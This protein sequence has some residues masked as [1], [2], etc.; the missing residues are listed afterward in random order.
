MST[1]IH[2]LLERRKIEV[3]LDQAPVAITS[4]CVAAFISALIFWK[5]EAHQ[6]ILA[7]LGIYLLVFGLRY[8]LITRFNRIPI[9]KRDYNG[10]LSMH[11]SFSVAAGL[12][13]SI[14]GIYVLD[15]LTIDDSIIIVLLVGGMV[16]GIVAT[17]SVLLKTYFAFSL[18]ASLP[19]I[20]YLLASDD[21]SRM[22]IMG[23]ML[24][25]FVLFVSFSAI[26]LNRLV[27]KSLAFQFDN[28]QL[29]EELEKE[30]NQVSRLASNL[31]FDLARRK[32]TEEQL[33]VEKE[34]AEQLAQSLL[35]M[36]TLD[37][38][39]GIPNRRHF[40]SI[41]AKEWNRASRTSSPISLIMCDIDN[42]KSYNDNYGH[43][44][45]DNCLIRIALL[46]QEHARREGDLAARYGGE[47]FVIILPATSLG[48]AT[49]IAEQMR[50]AIEELSI[51][52]RFSTSEN[53]VTASFGVATIVPRPDQQPRILISRADK[54]LYAAKQQGRNCVVSASPSL[55]TGRDEEFG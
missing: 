23:A 54:A 49:E 13:W 21:S 36:S 15:T 16:A 33:K 11:I 44:K 47:E 4:G 53:I 22:P 18:P 5:T 38:L 12:L 42:F 6:V 7:W 45:G 48:N 26:R 27:V 34:K 35:A 50:L 41:I 24:A 30:K 3:L 28:L 10:V 31:E 46:L 55:H 9:D 1:D 17:N 43:Q 8:W 37:G 39:T 29:L 40:D 19:V 32:K 14:L 52:H 25:T 2:Q 20:V 51:K